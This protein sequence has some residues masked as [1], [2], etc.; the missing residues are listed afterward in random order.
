MKRTAIQLGAGNI[1]RGFIGASMER[2]GYHVIFADIDG[3]IVDRINRDGQYTVN[4]ED[5]RPGS[6]IISDISAMDIRDGGLVEAMSRADVITTAV[7][8]GVLGKV[9]PRIA[10]GITARFKSGNTLPLNVIACEN[11]VGATSILKAEVFKLLDADERAFAQQNV[12]FADCSVDRIVPP[13]AY[14]NPIDV[15]VESFCEWNVDKNGLKEPFPKIEGMNLTDNLQAYIER[16]LFTLNTGHAITGYLGSLKG[17]KTTDEAIADPQIRAVVRGAMRESGEALVKKYGF[18][19][20]A[21]S[22]YIEKIITRFEN[23]YLK[24]DLARV[25]RD[26]LRKL[27]PQ[28]RLVKPLMAALEYGLSVDNLLTGIGAALRYDY[29]GDPQSA[30]MQAMIREQGIA[31]AVADITGITEGDPLMDR[32]IASYEGHGNAAA[33]EASKKVTI[34]AAH[35]MHARPAAEFVNL[36]KSLG[37]A[38]SLR[39]G[40]RSVSAASILG[41]LSLGLKC[42]AEVE[43]VAQG[44]NARTGVET[45]TSFIENL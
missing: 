40:A 27:S 14:D 45:I 28:D 12:G 22:D 42:G 4:I 18:E 13:S 20:S 33:Q 7:G 36:V 8:V 5:V 43:I 32:I 38:V 39:S 21:H 23:P 26:P 34:R 37:L 9:A 29:P 2:S 1:G 25:G 3:A 31:A 6:E 16:K 41:I 15:A 17:Y 44:K 24:D 11:A 30:G 19:R 35:G 10:S